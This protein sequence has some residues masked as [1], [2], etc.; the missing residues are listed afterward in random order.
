[1]I[2]ESNMENI[3][4]ESRSMESLCNCWQRGL[5]PAVQNIAGIVSRNKPL[6]EEVVGDNLIDLYYQR[7]CTIYS[8]KSHS[9][10]KDVLRDFMKC[11]KAYHFL[12]VHPKFEVEI[13]INGTDSQSKYP[14][15]LASEK[16]LDNGNSDKPDMSFVI[17]PPK[18]SRPAGRETFGLFITPYSL[19]HL[20]S[21][22]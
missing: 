7:L 20:T 8:A 11:M 21:C 19:V 10:K 9:Y 12:A 2:N 16:L 17:C 13:P 6:L 14:N 5:Q 22:L 3:P 18:K 4:V 1:M 15:A